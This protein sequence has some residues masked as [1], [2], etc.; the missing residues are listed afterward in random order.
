MYL[1]NGDYIRV[2]EICYISIVK[3]QRGEH[4]WNATMTKELVDPDTYYIDIK[5]AGH[6]LRLEYENKDEALR[7]YKA[8]TAELDA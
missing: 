7:E 1:H 4:R 6:E 3:T 2:S 5:L 8:I